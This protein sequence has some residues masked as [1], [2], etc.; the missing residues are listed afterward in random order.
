MNKIG[1]LGEKDQLFKYKD[2]GFNMKD[3]ELVKYLILY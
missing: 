1:F 3:K 2:V